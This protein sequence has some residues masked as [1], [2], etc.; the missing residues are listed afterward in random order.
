MWSKWWNIRV[1]F[2]DC[3]KEFDFRGENNIDKNYIVYDLWL[4]L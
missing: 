2:W 4:K 3:V 1:G